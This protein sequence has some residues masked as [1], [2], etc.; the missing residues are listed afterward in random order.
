[1]NDV[2]GESPRTPRHARVYGD[3][4]ALHEQVRRARVEALHAFR[5]DASSGRF[6]SPAEEAGISD[7]ELAALIARLDG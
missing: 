5:L 3:L 1:M 7:D 4:S 2:C 6:P